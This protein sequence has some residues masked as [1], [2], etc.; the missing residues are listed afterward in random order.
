MLVVVLGGRGG[1]ESSSAKGCDHF[2]H[3]ITS[4]IL[5]ASPDCCEHGKSGSHLPNAV[6]EAQNTSRTKARDHGHDSSLTGNWK[7]SLIDTKTQGTK[8][9]D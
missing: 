6:A 1:G 7:T 9:L 4:R 5:T 8:S 2:E 3:M